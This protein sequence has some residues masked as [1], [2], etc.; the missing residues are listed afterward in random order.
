MVS[1]GEAGEPRGWWYRHFPQESVTYEIVSLVP[2]DCC[3]NYLM[4]AL[5]GDGGF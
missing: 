4:E 5:K 1:A 3:N 2:S